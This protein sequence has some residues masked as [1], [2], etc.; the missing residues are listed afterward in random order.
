MKKTVSFIVSIVLFSTC[1]LCGCEKN[2]NSRGK[3]VKDREEEKEEVETEEKEE[4]KETA[5]TKDSE[6]AEGTV[7]EVSESEETTSETSATMGPS[8]H[9]FEDGKCTDCGIFWTGYVYEASEGITEE[10]QLGRYLYVRDHDSMLSSDDY[11]QFI[12]SEKNVMIQYWHEDGDDEWFTFDVNVSNELSSDERSS[13]IFSYR[14]GIMHY[15][16]EVVPRY[17]FVYTLEFLSCPPGIYDEIF[18]SKEEFLLNSEPTLSIYDEENYPFRIKAWE[19][20][21][22]EEIKALFEEAGYTYYSREEFLEMVWNDREMFSECIETG[23][24]PMNTTLEDAGV[25]WN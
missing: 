11:V 25:N 9:I 14:Y 22:E 2:D 12:I 10:G 4:T 7:A 23:L 16:D 8:G 3:K 20:M 5:D 21:T 15:E 17:K 24:A 1:L 18:G 19:E 13:V 6:G